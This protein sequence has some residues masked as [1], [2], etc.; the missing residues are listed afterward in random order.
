MFFEPGANQE[1]RLTPNTAIDHTVMNTCHHH[2]HASY[3]VRCIIRI[4]ACTYDIPKGKLRGTIASLV[5]PN[6]FVHAHLTAVSKF[7]AP[8]KTLMCESASH[9]DTHEACDAVS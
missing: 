1:A 9:S 2:N 5:S 3:Y 8:H 7:S 4:E 6:G